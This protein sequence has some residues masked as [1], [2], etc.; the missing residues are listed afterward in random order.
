MLLMHYHTQNSDGPYALPYTEQWCS[1]CTTLHRTVMLFFLHFLHFSHL[2]WT[3]TLLMHYPTEQL[4]SLCTTYTEQWYSLCTTIHRTVMHAPYALPYT[5]QWCSLCTTLHRTVI[6]FFLCTT[7]TEQWRSLCTTLHRRVVL[8][9]HHPT[10][11]SNAPYALPC[12][13]Q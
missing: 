8:P 9:N 10:L 1:L 4:C 5:E 11:N 2:H 13:E 12:T 7:Y 6:L 3:V